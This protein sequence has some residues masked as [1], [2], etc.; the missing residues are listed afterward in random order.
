MEK[1]PRKYKLNKT[2]E[3]LRN[4]LTRFQRITFARIFF[5]LLQTLSIFFSNKIKAFPFRSTENESLV[6]T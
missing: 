1:N 5:V 2:R 6:P 4:G 3:I